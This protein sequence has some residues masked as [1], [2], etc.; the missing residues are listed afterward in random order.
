[1]SDRLDIDLSRIGKKWVAY[2]DLLGF[3]ER[4]KHSNIVNVFYE[5][6]AFLLK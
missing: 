1:M 3:D 2:A 6:C 4:V 5:P